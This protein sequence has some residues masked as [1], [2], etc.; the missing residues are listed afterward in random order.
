MK[1][2]SKKEITELNSKEKLKT[3]INTYIQCVKEASDSNIPK[4]KTRN[5]IAIPWWTEELNKLKK[6]MTVK[7]RRI[8]YAASRRRRYV[9]E[10]YLEIKNKYEEEVAQAQ[11]NSWK[12]FCSKQDRESLWD[13]IYRVI[14]KT[15]KK[16]EDVLLIR[17]G[18]S[19]DAKESVKYVAETFFPDDNLENEIPE[20][21]H[22]RMKAN[23]MCTQTTDDIWDVP[24]TATELQFAT[25]SFY[26]RKAPGSDGLTADICAAAINVDEQIFLALLNKCLELSYF[27]DPWKEATVLALRKP[28][29]TDYSLA[30]SYRP[31]GLLSVM[32]KILEKMMV[33]RLK[34]YILPKL[35]PRQ[36]GFVPQRCTE[37]SLYDL[38]LH[39]K[40]NL[41]NKKISIVISLDIEE[42]F[43][44]AWWPAIKNRLME[45]KCPVNLRRLVNSYFTDRKVKVRHANEVFTKNNTKGCIQGSIG[46]AIS[47]NLLLDPL[48]NELE[49]R[50]VYCQAFADDIVLIFSGHVTSDI[51][52]NVDQTLSHI[53]EWGLKNKLKFAP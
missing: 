24:F 19:L 39:I 27:P 25:S 50:G 42:A 47:W 22:T 37:D 30:K 6:E 36:Y 16:H 43:D 3:T 18:K 2:I 21:Y 4:I 51:K 35:N 9:V 46:G 52:V 40:N 32:G 26:P 45:I 11:I 1:N 38:V 8:S 33:R 15:S 41:R 31:I 14:R 48:L 5:K 29:K 13:G 17:E 44:S 10:Q 34:Y 12:K 28:G 49:E 7:K 20:Q 53:Y 23:K